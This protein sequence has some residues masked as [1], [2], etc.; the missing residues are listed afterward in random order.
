MKDKMTKKKTYVVIEVY[1]G[2]YLLGK[3]KTNILTVSFELQKAIKKKYP[4]VGFIR[5]LQTRDE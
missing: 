5:K 4:K 1:D 2:D 3:V